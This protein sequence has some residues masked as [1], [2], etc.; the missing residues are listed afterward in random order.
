MTG[1]RRLNKKENASIA[2]FNQLVVFIL[3]WVVKK[4]RNV[5]AKKVPQKLHKH[6][7]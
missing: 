2:L 6:K 4:R 3:V 7:R 1:K 5:R